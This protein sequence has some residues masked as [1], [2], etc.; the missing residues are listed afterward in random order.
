M[1]LLVGIWIGGPVFTVRQ[2]LT[3]GHAGAIGG[4][5]HAYWLTAHSD[6]LYG[7]PPGSRD[8]FL[9]SPAFAQVIRPLAEL[10]FAWFAALVIAA[11]VACVAWLLWPL[12]WRWAIPLLLMVP[13]EFVLGNIY[14]LLTVAV[15]LALTGR[16][17]WWAAGWLTKVTPGG[18]GLLWHCARGEWRRAAASVFWTVGL[19]A[20]SIALWP[21]AWGDWAR[22]LTSSDSGPWV[23]VRLAL[24]ACLVVA[25][26]R[27]DW[28]WAAPVALVIGA[29]VWGA[30]NLVMLAA[31]PRI[32]RLR[33][34]ELAGREHG[35]HQANIAS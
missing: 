19:A 27:R 29:P 1:G 4:D 34:P 22:F 32:A 30:K 17:G 5:A 31:L 9:Y 23:A 15:V 8:A 20:V 35:E 16:P 13:R 7:A 12:G 26:A 11:D 24:A 14:G 21:S 25:G 18:L 6:H 2:F 28:R 3:Y 10:P 33:R